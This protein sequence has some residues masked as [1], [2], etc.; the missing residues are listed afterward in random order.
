MSESWAIFV[1]LLAGSASGCGRFGFELLPAFDGLGEEGPSNDASVQGGSDSGDGSS[2]EAGSPD[3][4]DAGLPVSG[5]AGLPSDAGYP[6]FDGGADASPPLSDGGAAGRDGTTPD[7]GA[8]F[9]GHTYALLGS[10]QDWDS[11]QSA[12]LNIGMH[13]VQIDDLA[14]Q[15][16]VWSLNGQQDAWIGATDIEQEG[17]WHWVSGGPQFWSG[18]DDTGFAVDGRF[19]YW[20][21]GVEPNNAGGA[22]H[23][24][25]VHSVTNGRWTDLPCNLGYGAICESD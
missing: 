17:L 24:A 9:N 5:D 15:T 21:P 2:I 10:K 7:A 18:N 22:E 3:S 12:C 23:C 13:L 19:Q 1:W 11:S 4:G 14:E 6:P 20:N 16:F 25:I 8:V